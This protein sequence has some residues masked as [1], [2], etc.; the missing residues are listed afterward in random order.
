M[1]EH[2]PDDGWQ[3]AKELNKENVAEALKQGSEI[4]V[5][6][7]TKKNMRNAAER[8]RRSARRKKNKMAKDARKRNRK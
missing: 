7:K 1:Q 5:F 4:V 2:R 6:E 3:P 8:A